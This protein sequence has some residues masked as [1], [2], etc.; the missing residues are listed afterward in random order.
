M[1]AIVKLLFRLIRRWG[2]T[3]RGK[4]H[5]VQYRF[6]TTGHFKLF[7]V[8]WTDYKGVDYCRKTPLTEDICQHCQALIDGGM[9]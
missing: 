7:C 3:S 6:Y 8:P 4:W 2:K 1:K 5:I 9:A